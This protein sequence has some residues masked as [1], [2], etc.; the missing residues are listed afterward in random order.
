MEVSAKTI[1]EVEFREKL[2]GYHQEDVDEFLEQVAAV[3]EQLTN[4]LQEAEARAGSPRPAA[5]APSTR[6]PADLEGESAEE[7]L[8]RT[9]VLAQRTADLAVQEAREE[10]DR[11]IA[12]AEQQG[13][14]VMADAEAEMRA[15]VD[16]LTAERD[17]LAE[18]VEALT[19]WL[20]THRTQLGRAL[21]AAQQ[22][23]QQGL[24]IASPPP[25]PAAAS[26]DHEQWDDADDEETESEAAIELD[27]EVE[28]SH[29]GET[30][31]FEP[32]SNQPDPFLDELRKAVQDTGPIGTIHDDLDDE[33]PLFDQELVD[34][35]RSGP[36]LRRK[37]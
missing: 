22:S 19:G 14:L 18:S 32:G 8:R 5:A 21:L 31:R 6:P 30:P 9:L 35:R 12:E 10:A 1:R 37:R 20:D 34:A 2:R 33:G 25:V 23:L 26:A 29:P 27:D 24:S 28:D 11:I 3:V 15:E 17:E 16:R 36:R 13:R 4:R 7:T